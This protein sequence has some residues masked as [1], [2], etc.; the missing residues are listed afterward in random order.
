V[1]VLVFGG[2]VARVCKPLWGTF[3]SLQEGGGAKATEL[4]DGARYIPPC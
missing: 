2:D 3:N 1:D 4:R